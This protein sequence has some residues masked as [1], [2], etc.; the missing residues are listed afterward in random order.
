MSE[1][2]YASFTCYLGDG[3][4]DYVTLPMAEGR[5]PLEL[6]NA[7]EHFRKLYPTRSWKMFS[8]GFE[9]LEPL[10]THLTPEQRKVADAEAERRMKELE[11]WAATL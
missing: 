10:Y 1:T 3:E 2:Q 8:T 9:D 5:H 11:A 4:F 6:G 7:V